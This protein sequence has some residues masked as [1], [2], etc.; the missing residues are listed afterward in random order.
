MWRL[1]NNALALIGAAAVIGLAAG[2]IAAVA[3]TPRVLDELERQG[4]LR[5]PEA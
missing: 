2:V 3:V 5:R 1:I 4:L